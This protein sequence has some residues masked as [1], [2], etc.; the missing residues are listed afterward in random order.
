M[1]AYDEDDSAAL[2]QVALETLID[3]PAGGVD[4]KRGEHVV[5]KQD[6]RARIDGTS[7][8]DARLHLN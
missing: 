2:Q 8:G 5:E 1:R 3:Y 6:I 4:I 7:E